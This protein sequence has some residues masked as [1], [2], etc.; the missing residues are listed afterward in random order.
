MNHISLDSYIYDP[1]NHSIKVMS[2]M[3]QARYTHTA[4]LFGKYVYAIGG[5][6]FGEDEEAI[7]ASCERFSIL[8]N[9]WDMIANLNVKRCTCFVI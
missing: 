8:D 3:N 5:R 2:K 4:I 7:L 9:K 6:Y 1:S